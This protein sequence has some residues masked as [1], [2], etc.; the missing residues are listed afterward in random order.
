MLRLA[1]A[2]LECDPVDARTATRRSRCACG[3]L[4]RLGDALYYAGDNRASL[5]AFREAQA[6]VAAELARKP[7]LAWLERIGESHWFVSGALEEYDAPGALR[8]AE[9][10]IATMRRVLSYGPDANAEKWLAILYNQQ[11]SLL[12]GLGRAAEAA[13]AALASVA[14]RERRAAAQPDDPRRAR[15]LA[16]GLRGAS[17]TLAKAGRKGEACALARRS[18]VGWREIAARGRLGKL[19]AKKGFPEARA[20]AATLCAGS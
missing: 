1:L 4:N 14:I 2:R 7:T 20:V 13:P 11:A 12:A 9:A 17:E 16:V 18:V 19:D 10:G 15:D 6:I 8:E 3:L 5:A